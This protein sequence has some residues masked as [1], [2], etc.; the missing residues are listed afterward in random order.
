MA[1]LWKRAWCSVYSSK[2]S[3]NYTSNLKLPWTC[4]NSMGM[5]AFDELPEEII[6]V[7][8]KLLGP[9]E[10]AKLTLVSRSWRGVIISDNRLWVYFLHNYNP[11]LSSSHPCSN[12]P[13]WGWESIFFSEAHLRSGLPLQYV[14]NFNVF[15]CNISCNLS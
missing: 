7:I 8:L 3:S 13:S 12:I 5:G 9:K 11:I 2:N 10:A 14:L 15:D 6:T 1:Y 4:E